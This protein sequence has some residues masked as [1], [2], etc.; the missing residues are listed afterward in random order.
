M[1]KVSQNHSG[2][3]FITLSAHSKIVTHFNITRSHRKEL[4]Q[5]RNTHLTESVYYNTWKQ[6]DFLKSRSTYLFPM[7]LSLSSYFPSRPTVNLVSGQQTLPHTVGIQNGKTES[8]ITQVIGRTTANKQCFAY[9]VLPFHIESL[10][11]IKYMCACLFHVCIDQRQI[12][13]C[14]P[15]G[16]LIGLVP[17]SPRNLPVFVSPAPRL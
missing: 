16:S 10:L 4:D 3:M 15:Q 13:G 2:K 9:P 11:H 5:L 14:C 12:S 17:R 6:L 7:F 8:Q 1:R